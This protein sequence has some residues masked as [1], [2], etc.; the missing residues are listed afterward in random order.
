MGNSG[1]AAGEV[2]NLDSSPTSQVGRQNSTEETPTDATPSNGKPEK[3]NSTKAR[4]PFRSES[5]E[6]AVGKWGQL[7][8]DK[9]E[10]VVPV[11]STSEGTLT[12]RKSLEELGT[13]IAQKTIAPEGF[14]VLF[15]NDSPNPFDDPL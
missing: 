15:V 11:T 5:I 7:S 10:E 4:R 12:H 8:V 1:E 3:K 2:S 14:T 13:P 6:D 9:D